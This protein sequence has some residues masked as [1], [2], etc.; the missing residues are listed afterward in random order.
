MSN[1][2]RGARTISRFEPLYGANAGRFVTF[3]PGAHKNRALERRVLT[4]CVETL[5]RSEPVS[6]AGSGI[7]RSKTTIGGASV[8]D[9]EL[10]N[11]AI[12]KTGVSR[13][14]FAAAR[15]WVTG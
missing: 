4:R 14:R 5:A 15:Q 13:I 7:V 2:V 9:V 3:V 11:R 10:V 1:D 12:Q 8:L 6:K